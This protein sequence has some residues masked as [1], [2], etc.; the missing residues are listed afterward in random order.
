VVTAYRGD[1]PDHLMTLAQLRRSGRQPGEVGTVGNWLE[2]EFD[3]DWWRTPL[4]DARLARPLAQ[5]GAPTVITLSNADSRQ[6]A[7]LW[8]GAILRD[9]RAVVLDNRG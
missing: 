8:A 4:Y 1:V 3:G 6:E 9:E 5:P 2:R 7:G